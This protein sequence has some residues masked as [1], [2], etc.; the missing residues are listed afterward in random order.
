ME[1]QGVVSGRES[2]SRIVG[3]AVSY[4]IGKNEKKIY[5]YHTYRFSRLGNEENVLYFSYP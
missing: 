1:R 3:R 4:Q 5:K 2:G